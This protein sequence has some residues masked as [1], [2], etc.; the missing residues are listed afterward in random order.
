MSLL[1]LPLQL[2]IG[3]FEGDYPDLFIFF[4]SEFP[5]SI[6]R[7]RLR[8]TFP[9]IRPWRHRRFKLRPPWT[10]EQIKHILSLILGI[11]TNLKAH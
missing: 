5:D 1:N 4:F 7:A 8:V 11:N 10:A 6:S 3:A 9:L 2:L